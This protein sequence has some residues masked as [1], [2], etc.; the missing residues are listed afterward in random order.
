MFE[1]KA[2]NQNCALLLSFERG[3][4]EDSTSIA[5]TVDGAGLEFG[6]EGWL[7]AVLGCLA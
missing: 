7:G 3:V 4:G 1:D 2:A 6:V 5:S